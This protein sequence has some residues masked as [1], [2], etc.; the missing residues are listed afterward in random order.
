M[1]WAGWPVLAVAAGLFEAGYVLL[2]FRGFSIL[3]W[4]TA[5]PILIVTAQAIRAVIFY[6]L[7][8]IVVRQAFMIVGL[9]RFLSEFSVA[10]APLHPDKAGGLRVL[11]DYVLKTGF[12]IGVIGLNFGMGLLRL[13]WNP[14]ELTAEFYISMVLY[15][16]LAPLLFFSPLLQIHRQMQ[17]A[18]KKLL[19]E[20]AEQFDLEYHKLLDGL[21]RNELSDGGIARVEAIQK[22]YQIAEGSPAWPFDVE[23]ASKF[24]AAAMLPV[25]IPLGIEALNRIFFR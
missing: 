12:F 17:S 14:A 19:V 22:I 5:N 7:V 11:G 21:R 10:I 9:N 20:I 15:L 18:K 3:T 2:I 13:R 1:G 4:E 24:A 23:I 25:L 16:I 6:M 8:F